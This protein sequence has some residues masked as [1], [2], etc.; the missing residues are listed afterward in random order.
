MAAHCAHINLRC[1]AHT[2]SGESARPDSPSRESDGTMTG[3]REHSSPRVSPWS[4]ENKSKSASG[5]AFADASLPSNEDHGHQHGHEHGHKH[6]HE[7]GH[8]G[9]HN[10]HHEDHSPHHHGAHVAGG[11]SPARLQGRV[12]PWSRGVSNSTPPVSTSS[13]AN[14]A[15]SS[16]HGAHQAGAHLSVPGKLRRSRMSS[17]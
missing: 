6:D 7:H 2:S 16:P 13:S 5:V 14:A 8:N 12:S 17:H 11:L 4:R 1:Q 9:H 15:G 3:P 10:G